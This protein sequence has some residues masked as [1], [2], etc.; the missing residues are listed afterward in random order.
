MSDN[1]AR[2]EQSA[3]EFKQ[4]L[5]RIKAADFGFPWY[6]YETM[7]N[8][9]HLRPLVSAQF[10]HL[11]S[12]GKKFADIGAADGDMAFF[13]ESRG[14][15]V[16]IYDYAPTNMNGLRGARKIK[17]VLSSSVN[18]HEVDLDSQMKL[19]DQYDVIILL[20]I[21]YHLKN[22]YYVLET[23]AKSCKYLVTST[24][25]AR[26]FYAG[27]PDMSQVSAAYLL[28]PT[29]SNNDATNFW[30]FSDKGLRRIFERTG[31]DVGTYRTVGDVA[32]SNPQDM[33]RDERAF[34]LL[35]SRYF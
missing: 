3:P 19:H 25:V 24:R 30:I 32:M 15:K 9:G 7:N 21:L 1:F 17:E 13:L 4:K 35:Q 26:H 27:G 2:L 33:A 14:N 20:G 16:D 8:I 28:D 31:W 22:P 18:I 29:E 11:F 12:G 10:D 5:A 6:P 23:L 34:A